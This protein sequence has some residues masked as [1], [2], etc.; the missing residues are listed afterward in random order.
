[1]EINE[2][3]FVYYSVQVIRRFCQISSD[4]LYGGGAPCN[5]SA[6]NFHPFFRTGR[7]EPSARAATLRA[8]SLWIFRRPRRV[9]RPAA[10]GGTPGRRRRPSTAVAATRRRIVRRGPEP[11]DRGH[12]ALYSVRPR[13]IYRTGSYCGAAAPRRCVCART[14]HTHE[15]I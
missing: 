2:F 14:K 12:R 5:G 7:A 4:Y 9:A 1:M 10:G 8:P 6:F 13:T 11:V 3:L 15:Y